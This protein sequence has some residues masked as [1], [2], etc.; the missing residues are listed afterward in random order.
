[1]R[2]INLFIEEYTMNIKAFQK[3]LKQKTK[4]KNRSNQVDIYI[5]LDDTYDIT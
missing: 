4:Q 3:N 2:K 1:M 5:I